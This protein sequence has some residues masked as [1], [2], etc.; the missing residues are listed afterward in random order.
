MRRLVGWIDMYVSL[1]VCAQEFTHVYDDLHVHALFGVC[2]C[3]C[4]C[5]RTVP[6]CPFARKAGKKRS[7][8][9]KKALFAQWAEVLP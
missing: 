1:C 2:L 4:V 9:E 7:C 3:V 8:I 6:V 5:V